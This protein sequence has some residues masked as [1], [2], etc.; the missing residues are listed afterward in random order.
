MKTLETLEKLRA[1]LKTSMF[2][3]DTFTKDLLRVVISDAQ[4]NSKNPSEEEVIKVL[5]RMVKSAK[6][7][8]N[9]EEIEILETYLPQKMDAVTLT[10]LI[11]ETINSQEVTNMKEMG[12]IMSVIKTHDGVDMAEAS[13]IIKEILS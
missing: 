7:C 4:R 6:E 3:K 9:E 10:I 11:T 1:D 12:K 8:K 5:K 13:K 2:N